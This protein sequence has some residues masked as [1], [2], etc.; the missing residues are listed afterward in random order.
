MRED[1]FGIGS[2]CRNVPRECSPAEVRRRLG[3]VKTGA[4]APAAAR[5]HYTM[6]LFNPSAYDAAHYDEPTRRALLTVRHF[7][8]S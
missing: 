1:R 7:F 4:T 2:D 5:S 3:A 8:E 6:L